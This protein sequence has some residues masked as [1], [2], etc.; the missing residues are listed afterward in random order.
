MTRH[1]KDPLRM[2]SDSERESLE[3]VSRST[4]LP[5]EQVI[6]AKLILAV[7][8]RMNYTE[9]ARSVGRRSNDAISRL[10]SRFNE[11]GLEGLVPGHGGG[12]A[13]QY[14]ETEK[15]RILREFHRTPERESDGTATWSVQTLQ[16]ALRK[17]PDGLPQVST[18]TIR[19]VLHE[20][21]YEWQQSR[22]WCQTGTVI[23]KRKQG[24]VQVTD[25]D[26]EAKKS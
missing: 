23:R 22:T 3:S 26:T 15:E 13:I 21:G 7:A 18:W 19:A 10:V 1:L 11:V 25:P 2:L 24:K 5:S 20:A 9:A 14:G 16:R 4:S 6:R 12:F 8:N 17:A